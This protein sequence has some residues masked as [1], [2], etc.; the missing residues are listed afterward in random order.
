MT[1][2][3]VGYT[4]IRD[5]LRGDDSG[6]WGSVWA[7]RAGPGVVRPYVI[8]SLAAGSRE[9][10]RGDRDNAGLVYTVKCVADR[11]AEAIVG[12]ARIIA[13]LDGQGSQEGAGL[14]TDGAWDVLTVTAETAVNFVEAFEGVDEVYHAGHQYRL[15]MESK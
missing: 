11:L 5:T 1:A 9:Q 3:S 14:V 12:Q 15:D 10:W 13:L 4:V 6:A 7:E 2:E 8:V